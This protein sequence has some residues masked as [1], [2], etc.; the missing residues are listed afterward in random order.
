M[1]AL[2]KA[3][4]TRGYL[5]SAVI[6]RVLA[7]FRLVIDGTSTYAE[8]KDWLRPFLEV[9]GYKLS[10]GGPLSLPNSDPYLLLWHRHQQY[11]RGDVG[12]DQEQVGG[13]VCLPHNRIS[14]RGTCSCTW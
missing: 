7:P 14:I 1:Q 13:V 12:N 10:D 11:S 6:P 3:A 9:E 4:R 5:P 2:E 8:Y